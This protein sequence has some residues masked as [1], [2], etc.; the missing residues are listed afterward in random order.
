MQ[1][2]RPARPRLLRATLVLSALVL[3]AGCGSNFGA[4]TNRIYQPAEGIIDRDGDVYALNVLAVLDQDRATLIG[5]LLNQ[6]RRTDALVEVTGNGDGGA[7]F[8]A[9]LAGSQLELPSRQLVQMGDDAAVSLPADDV[10]LGDV[11]DVTLTFR[12]ATPI[13][14][15]VPVVARSGDYATVPMPQ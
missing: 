9:E 2:R 14:M 11:V 8:T 10:T 6:V 13:S 12:N 7:S 4:Q 3:S 1:P 15:S 5:A